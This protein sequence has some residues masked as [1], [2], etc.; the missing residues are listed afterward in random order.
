MTADVQRMIITNVGNVGIGTLSPGF[1][2]EVNGVVSSVAG[3]FRFPD[4]TVQTTAF[5]LPFAK[6]TSSSSTLF[7]LTNT[8]T[9]SVA[10]FSQMAATA[11]PALSVSTTGPDAFAAEIS[12]SSGT[13]TNVAGGALHLVV[14]GTLN[15]GLDIRHNGDGGNGI[16]VDLRPSLGLNVAWR[17]SGGPITKN[18]I[19]VSV[20]GPNTAA[21]VE[22]SSTA[23][24]LQIDTG[25][26]KV[27][28]IASATLTNANVLFEIPD[29]TT[30]VT[31]ATSTLPAT[32]P[33]GQIIFVSCSDPD[34]CII[35]GCTTCTLS[36]NSTYA[37]HF[38]RTS[39]GWKRVL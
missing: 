34:G 37:V 12:S 28:S 21:G 38:I 35:N 25:G 10:S 32:A 2:L 33:A 11:S 7:D 22:I 4:A 9:G 24:A 15:D 1:R 20:G 23:Q 13:S 3:G 17:E 31:P 16:F 18:G 26:L 29:N 30:A 19:V 14:N 36:I 6:T 39:D 8:G 5:A 27:S